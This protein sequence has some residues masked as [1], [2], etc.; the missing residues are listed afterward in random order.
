MD[1]LI[2]G[3]TR[4]TYVIGGLLAIDWFMFLDSLDT[5]AR[6]YGVLIGAAT[7]FANVIFQVIKLRRHIDK[8]DE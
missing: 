6:A 5:H 4:L 3:A 2:D 8:D 7:F 1:R